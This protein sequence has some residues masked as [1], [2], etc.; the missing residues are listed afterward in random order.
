MNKLLEVI[1]NTP[2]VKIDKIYCDSR[3]IS[4]YIKMEG[5]NPSG[6]TKDRS[7][8]CILE[9][10]LNTG[11]LNANSTVIESSSGNFG[12][13]VAQ[14]CNCLG[15]KFIS[16]VDE[17]ITNTNLNI[18]KAYGAQICFI[19][20]E[21]LKD[22]ESLLHKRIAT[23]QRLLKEIPNSFSPNQYANIYNVIGHRKTMEEIHKEVGDI[24]YI[25]VAVS[26][27][28][29]VRG[30]AEYIKMNKMKTKVIAVD[31]VGSVIFGGKSKKRLLPGH[32]AARRSELFVDNL[33]DDV[34]YVDDMECVRGCRLLL[35]KE[36]IMAGASTGGIITAIGKY[37]EKISKDSICVAI[38]HD[39]GERYLGT[40]YS[41]DW[42]KDN[43]GVEL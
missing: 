9:H 24:D 11:E 21:D 2:I 18:L 22:G 16:V 6:S 19:S 8:L 39:R 34:V 27:F 14:L 10:A 28:G 40:V 25:F 12:I 17:N 7:A 41:D 20:S 33:V 30:Y 32:G 36:G 38:M 3:N 31:A 29:T 13:A 23:V 42:V 4:L 43:F 37:K 35:Q 15:I 26:T 5:L 1:G